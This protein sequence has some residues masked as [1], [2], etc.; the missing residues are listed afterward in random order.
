MEGEIYTKKLLISLSMRFGNFWSLL[1]QLSHWIQFTAPIRTC[2]F[3]QI[4]VLGVFYPRVKWL[5]V[6]IILHRINIIKLVEILYVLPILVILLALYVFPL[7]RFNQRCNSSL[8]T[9]NLVKIIPFFLP[10]VIYG[11]RSRAKCIYNKER[12]EMSNFN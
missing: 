10:F 5:L 7:M 11:Y 3:L 9:F 4:N 2:S 1:Y 6:Q 8:L 12:D